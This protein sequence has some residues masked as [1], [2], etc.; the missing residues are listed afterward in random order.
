AWRAFTSG[1]TAHVYGSG[2]PAAVVNTLTAS[3]FFERVEPKPAN[4]HRNSGAVIAYAHPGIELTNSADAPVIADQPPG[5][6]H[7]ALNTHRELHT[8]L[9]ATGAGVPKGSAGEIAQTRIFDLV[10]QLLGL[11][12][13]PSPGGTATAPRVSPPR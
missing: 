10:S 11:S 1:Y 12:S 6:A 8:V 7:G 3:G 13:R 9:F 2:D 4:A 5:G